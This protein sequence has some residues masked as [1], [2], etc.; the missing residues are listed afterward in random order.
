[1]PKQTWAESWGSKPVDYD[2]DPEEL[3]KELKKVR[4]MT[5]RRVSSLNKTKAFSFAA[6]Q[7]E[8]TMKKQYIHG[9]QPNINTMK[10]QAIEKELR[11]HHQFWSAQTATKRGAYKE[12]VAQSKRIF[13]VDSKGKPTR[14]MT[15]DEGK[16]FWS[17]YYEFAN[18]YKKEKTYLDSNR[19]QRILGETSELLKGDSEIDL[20]KLL[21]ITR[22]VLQA[23]YD[24]VSP[25]DSKS[26]KDK[27][28]EAR[29]VVLSME[30]EEE[31]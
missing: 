23:D 4:N 8:Q 11:I 13:G 19:V 28:M 6:F 25:F 14:L 3:A 12:Q 7:Y 31:E 24:A 27:I 16:E 18:M 26:M 10:Y 29:K 15:F 9:K 30:G 1:M 5:A 2:R 22:E 17:A 21:A 20:V